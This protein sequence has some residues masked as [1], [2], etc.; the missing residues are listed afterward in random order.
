M[1]FTELVWNR[2]LYRKETE[3]EKKAQE[4]SEKIV[5]II[6]SRY[7]RE[8]SE[9][10]AVREKLQNRARLNCPSRDSVVF[11]GFALD[12]VRK[13]IRN[14][15]PGIF[16]LFYSW[17]RFLR[18]LGKK[19]LRRENLAKYGKPSKFSVTMTPSRCY[20]E[21]APCIFDVLW[22]VRPRGDLSSGYFIIVRETESAISSF[23]S[24]GASRYG[25]LAMGWAS[26][27]K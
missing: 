12:S 11:A 27:A 2:K 26:G 21:I 10:L 6:P 15:V 4:K 19:I 8:E 24:T 7:A 23:I 20:P 16:T 1:F 22:T 9:D 13:I 3:Q 25:A 17:N 14:E 18:K 5:K